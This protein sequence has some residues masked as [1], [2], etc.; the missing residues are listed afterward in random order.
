MR[1]LLLL[2]LPVLFGASAASARKAPQEM[3]VIFQTYEFAPLAKG[4]PVVIIPAKYVVS[5]K[6]RQSFAEHSFITGGK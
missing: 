4:N 2:L 6:I 5:P 1:L 3:N